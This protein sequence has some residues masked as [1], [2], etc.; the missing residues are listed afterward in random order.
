MTVSSLGTRWVML[1]VEPLTGTRSERRWSV[2]VM[3]RSSCNSHPTEVSRMGMLEGSTFGDQYMNVCYIHRMK[4]FHECVVPLVPWTM[5]LP[6][7]VGEDC[8]LWFGL[9]LHASAWSSDKVVIG[10]F[11]PSMQNVSPYATCLL[12]GLRGTH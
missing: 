4:V 12:G 3:D 9:H 2:V 10:T 5:S 6:L 8:G 11:I 1:W 7:S